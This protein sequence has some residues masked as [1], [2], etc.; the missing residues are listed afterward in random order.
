MFSIRL[1]FF[2][3][4][5]YF[6]MASSMVNMA[7]G[8]F[9]AGQFVADNS[10]RT[11]RRVDNSSQDNSSQDNSSHGQF[12]AWTIRRKTIRCTDYSSQ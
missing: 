2:D 7:L 12:V 1:D 6:S 3:L 9:V 11:I 4:E 8:Q 10:L 5:R